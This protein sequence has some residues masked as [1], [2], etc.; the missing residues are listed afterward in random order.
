MADRGN[1]ATVRAALDAVAALLAPGIPAVAAQV[2]LAHDEPE[3]YV[4]AYGERLE[5]RGIDEPFPGLPWIALVDALH[6]HRRLA[7][8]DWKEGPDEIRW[9]LGQLESRPAQDPWGRI[10][11]AE[12]QL[13]TY[14]YLEACGR[15]HREVGTALVVLDI[16]SD[17]YP[18]ACLPAE[19]AE[20]LS[21]T[22]TAAGFT[23]WIAGAA[24]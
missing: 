12:A 6:E 21:A 2:L 11:D 1:E 23:A 24:A 14:E 10:G 8:F 4:R 19:R 18:V 17:C 5:D 22:A 13:P 9:R 20:E 16:E 15:A 3:A 7:E